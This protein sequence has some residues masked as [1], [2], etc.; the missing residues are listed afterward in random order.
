MHKLKLYLIVLAC[1]GLCGCDVLED[2]GVH[3][4][5]CLKDGAKQ[6]AGSN[7]SELVIPYEPLTGTN[8]IYD[9]EFVPDS[10]VLVSGKNGGTSTY[11]LNYVHVGKRFDLVKTNAATLAT[12]RKVGGRIDVVDVR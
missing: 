1:A 12:L 3:M 2:N 10:L 9:V 7:E 4:A 6:L 11:H 5:Y 8:Q